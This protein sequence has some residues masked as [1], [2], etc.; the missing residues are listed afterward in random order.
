LSKLSRAFLT[1]CDKNTEWM[2]E[3]F[4]KH[5][6]K[7]NDT[8]IIFANFGVSNEKLAELNM[9]GF[10]AIIDMPIQKGQGWFYKPK[11]MLEAA[12]LS[13]EVCW[14]DTDIHTL[15]DMSGIFDYVEDNKLCMVEDKPWSA[16]RGEKWHNSGVVAFRG[17]PDIL[18]KWEKE[19][20]NKPQVGDQEVLHEMMRITPMMRMMHIS[21]APNK[22][23]WL[24]IQLMDG[25]DSPNKV[26]MH[27]TGPKGKLQ[28]QKIMYNE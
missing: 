10:Y 18:R 8:P 26:A 3:W 4:V 28:I 27:W 5:Y 16:R 12:E 17:V 22:Y 13:E 21:D 7:H 2:L 9:Y 1:G 14:V 19:C 11:A 23:N 20:S 25:Q 15:G 24:R 6:K